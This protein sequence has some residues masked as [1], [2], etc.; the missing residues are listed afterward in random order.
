MLISVWMLSVTLSWLPV[1]PELTKVSVVPLT[2]MLSPA[3]KP[4]VIESD[5]LAPDSAVAP[6]AMFEAGG[7][8]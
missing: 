7:A 6:V 5:P 3:E 4:G 1:A 2:V 8:T